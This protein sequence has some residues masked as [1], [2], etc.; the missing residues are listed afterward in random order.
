M[1]SLILSLLLFTNPPTLTWE[2]FKGPVP[3]TELIVAARTYTALGFESMDSAGIFTCHV[4]AQFLNN[5]SW[6]RYP[7]EAT[8]RHETVHWAI[9][10]L[11]AAICNKALAKYQNKP[12]PSMKPV[13]KVFEHYQRQVDLLNEQFDHE[14]NHGQNAITEAAYERHIFNDLN[15]LLKFKDRE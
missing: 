4:A 8:L 12:L 3:E 5:L 15:K 2:D 14:T 1:H 13:T 11:Y 10:Q 7:S 9:C 6:V